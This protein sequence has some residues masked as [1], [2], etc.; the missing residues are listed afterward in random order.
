MK[1]HQTG[2]GQETAA[3]KTEV[4]IRSGCRIEKGVREKQ[5][6]MKI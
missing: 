3:A 4:S 6:G 1:N 2:H 5:L